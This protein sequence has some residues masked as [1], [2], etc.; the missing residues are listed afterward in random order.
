MLLFSGFFIANSFAQNT[1]MGVSPTEMVSL[2]TICGSMA[3]P[4][5]K[6]DSNKSSTSGSQFRRTFPNGTQTDF[7]IP[8]GKYLVITDVEWYYT[9]ITDTA[10]DLDNKRIVFIL[11]RSSSGTGLGSEYVLVSHDYA[12]FRECDQ[13][14][15]DVFDG[16]SSGCT[17]QTS[18]GNNLQTTSGLVVQAGTSLKFM[19]NAPTDETRRLVVTLRGYLLPGCTIAGVPCR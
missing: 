16:Q 2:F 15:W 1:H 8:A 10:K 7:V 17:N 11:R 3:F 14:V 6:C 4:A 5:S 13:D 18:A 9:D 19:I 12:Q